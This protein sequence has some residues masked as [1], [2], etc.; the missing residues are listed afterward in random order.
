[1][2]TQKQRKI[3]ASILR[4]EVI[5]QRLTIPREHHMLLQM[6]EKQFEF[7]YER[8][9]LYKGYLESIRGE[10]KLHKSIQRERRL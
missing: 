8:I 10:R 9:L 4:K 3:Y 6:T 7:H 1:M 2:I 5:F